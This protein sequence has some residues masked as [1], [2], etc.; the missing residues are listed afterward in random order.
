MNKYLL[1]SIEKLNSE[2]KNYP[3]T[4]G[5][6]ILE[7]L[8]SI[9]KQ[10]PEIIL[11]KTGLSEFKTNYKILSEKTISELTVLLETETKKKIAIDVLI[12]IYILNGSK[13][14]LFSNI[15]ET[16]NL[17]T[18]VLPGIKSGITL[19][20]QQDAG[21]IISSIENLTDEHL[22]LLVSEWAEKNRVMPKELT[23]KPGAWDNDYT[24]YL[25]RIMDALSQLS[26]TRK[27][28]LMKG[29][30][31]GA[32]T[33][34]LEN[35]IG[36]TIEH[37][38]CGMLF[39]TGDA[40]LAK[41]AI[42]IKV[43]KM[44]ANCGLEN[45]IYNPDA[46][47]KKTGNTTTQKDFDGGFLLSYGAKSPAKLRQMSFRNEAADEFD[48]W[49]D[50]AGKEGSIE[51]LFEN[52][53]ASFENTRKILYQSTPLI[54]Q[55]SK[56][57]KQYL[58][59]DQQ[60]FFVPCPKCNHMQY[61]RLQGVRKDGKKFAFKYEVDE[62]FNLII[63]S[64]CY[65]CE[66]CLHSIK[67][68][69]KEW[70]IKRGEWRPTAVAKEADFESFWLPS[71]YAPIG[72]LSWEAIT[73]KWLKWWDEKNQRVKDIESY[74]TFKNTIEG[75]PFE[76]R[77]ASPKYEKVITHRRAV[78]S[79]N[80]IKNQI[81][82]KE[83]GSRILVITLAADVHKDRIDVEILGWCKDGRTYSIDWR[84]IE[85]DTEDLSS[86]NSP[87]QKLSNIIETET[88]VSDDHIEYSVDITAVDA[89]YRTDEVY[90]FTGQYSEGV[91][92]IFGRDSL[93]KNKTYKTLFHESKNKYGNV[94]YTLNVNIYKDRLAAWLRSDWNDGEVQPVGYPNY[95]QDYGDDYFR[96]Y[97]SE[98]KV[99]EYHK[100]TKQRLGF[101]WRKIANKDNHAW[102]DRVYNMAILDFYAYNICITELGHEGIVYDDFWKY[103]MEQLETV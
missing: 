72:M 35:W 9:E 75:W 62:N 60:H 26:S 20:Q 101:Y 43:D 14:D 93:P 85:G 91:Y 59:G 1:Q 63:D 7:I 3:A 27:V 82:I 31:I 10:T 69:D 16:Q 70:F 48:A 28:A 18:Q 65:L 67:N 74:K 84:N 8:K 99:T 29:M 96:Q 78:Y 39:V 15:E 4:K 56:I 51:D 24:K 12:A 55:T 46:K 89:G 41:T 30:Q 13:G 50:T 38:P 102:D 32:S 5:V 2:Y 6:I 73:V 33:G 44:I 22:T 61:L 88:W 95:P 36:Y 81:C 79:R 25:V 19:E 66:S 57:Y 94:F 58:L 87:W 76:E 97:E 21:Y 71:F 11:K 98:E 80:E 37:D 83:T 54:L 45:L 40:E 64:V 90:Q 100:K 53:S 86:V 34:I 49:P 77:G 92:P 52:R 103:K 17:Q 23:S 47:S 42:N 68:Y